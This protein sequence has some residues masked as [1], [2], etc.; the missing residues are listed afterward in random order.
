MLTRREADQSIFVEVDSEGV[1]ASDE[2][3][4][5]NVKFSAVNKVRIFHIGL[6]NLPECN[7]KTFKSNLINK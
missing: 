2:N 1:D 7:Q 5:P 4:Q 6:N 3:I